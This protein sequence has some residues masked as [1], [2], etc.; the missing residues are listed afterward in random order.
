MRRTIAGVVLFFLLLPEVALHAAVR[1]VVLILTDGVNQAQLELARQ[2]GFRNAGMSNTAAMPVSGTLLPLPG[3]F[4]RPVIAVKNALATGNGQDRMLGMTP[5]DEVIDSLLV[6]AKLQGRR[7]GFVTDGALNDWTGG[8]FFA[9]ESRL[10]EPDKLADWLPLCD[11]DLLAGTLNRPQAPALDPLDAP[12]AK[13]GYMLAKNR[14][15]VREAPSDRRL[16]ATHSLLGSRQFAADRPKDSNESGLLDYVVRAFAW[17]Q[18]ARGMFLIADCS[19]IRLAAAANDTAALIRELW[20]FDRVLG[21]AVAFYKEYPEDTLVVVVSLYDIG[22]LQLG[23]EIGTDFPVGATR[24]SMLAR[25]NASAL[26]FRQA[27]KLAGADELFAP[28]AEELRELERA[29]DVI[30]AKPAPRDFRLWLDRVLNLRDRHAGVE[31]LTRAATI[32]LTPVLAIG[33]GSETFAGE[34]NAEELHRKLAAAL[35]LTVR[36]E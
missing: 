20:M 28:G 25:L 19:K 31:W 14:K 24:A 15:Q 4:A 23:R 6:R 16:F 5:A 36:P 21:E 10:P 33:T 18:D 17:P 1:N 30:Q 9:H 34:Y 2:A 13:L 35:G 12:M 27:L 7:T 32:S 11:F 29:Y 8:A 26:T 22:D 3:D